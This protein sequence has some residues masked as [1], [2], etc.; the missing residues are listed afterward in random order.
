MNS[1]RTYYLNLRKSIKSNEIWLWL[2]CIALIG[3]NNYLVINEIYWFSIVPLILGL[4]YL[5]FV[6]PNLVIYFITF[7]IP[8]TIKYDFVDYGFSL[9]L[10]AEPLIV[11]LAFLWFLKLAITGKIE[12]NIL[13]SPLGIIILINLLWVFVT[14]LSSTIPIVS[15]KFFFA[16]F[17]YVVVFFVMTMTIFTDYKKVRSFFWVYGF[18]IVCVILYTIVQHSM[19]FFTQEYSVRASMPFFS[20]HTIYGAVIALL[21]PTFVIFVLKSRTMELN[22]SQKFFSLVITVILLIGLLFSYSRAAW[23]SIGVSFGFFILLLFRMKFHYVIALIILAAT[24]VYINWT[25][26]ITPLKFKDKEVSSSKFESHIKS[27]SNIT[28]DASNTERLNRWN[29]ALRM[30]E[31]K[32]VLGWGPGTYMFKYAPFQLYKDR[33]IISTNRGNLGNAHSEYLGPLAESGLIGLLIIISLAMIVLYTG[34]KIYFNHPEV[35]IRLLSL[36]VMLGLVSY[37]IHGF[38][39]DFLEIDKAAVLFW[40]FISILA[41]FSLDLKKYSSD[42][43]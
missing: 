43:L 8:F 11:V 2:I 32:P 38:L 22:S 29:C 30:F 21:L 10:P 6:N 3:L 33:T 37:F 1:L 16:R 25:D 36:G 39:N 4:I 5:A 12:K 28:T 27:I 26:I 20:D 40:A 14:S 35:K 13:K 18:S 9:S 42:N 19:H 34:M 23:V 24:L 15:F 17:C 7:L 31:Q 41:V